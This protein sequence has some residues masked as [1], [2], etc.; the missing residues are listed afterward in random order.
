MGQQTSGDYNI[1][2]WR[3]EIGNALRAK[4]KHLGVQLHLYE[5]RRKEKGQ[6]A[7]KNSCVAS[8][9]VLWISVL[10]GG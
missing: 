2:A 6:V 8:L 9:Q 1:I 5:E 7:C 4:S 10:G 3:L